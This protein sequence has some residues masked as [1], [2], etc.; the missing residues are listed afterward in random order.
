MTDIG[1]KF[2][3]KLSGLPRSIVEAQPSFE[4]SIILRIVGKGEDLVDDP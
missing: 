4:E 1:E 2:V 3:I